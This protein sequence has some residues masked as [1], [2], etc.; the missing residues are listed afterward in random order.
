MSG[1][2]R[3]LQPAYRVPTQHVVEYLEYRAIQ[4]SAA[5]AFQT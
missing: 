2:H 5:G 4:Q 1:W 3:Y